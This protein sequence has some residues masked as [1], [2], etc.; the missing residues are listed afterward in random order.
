MAAPKGNDYW[1]NR[2]RTG[3]PRRFETPEELAQAFNDYFEYAENNPLKE[4]QL[5]KTKV[6]RD[7]EEVKVYKRP[8]PRILTIQ[9][10]CAF[11]GIWSSILYEYEKREGYKEI[12]AR[13]KELMYG[14]K[15][16]GAAAGLFNPSIIA[17]E[18]GLTE[19][20]ETR[21]I[22]EQPL[23]DDAESEEAD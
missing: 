18:L 17:R 10:F 9:G 14:Q 22:Q 16:E 13:A 15:I 1:R 4:A 12:I 6:Y 5:V 11:T 21:V 19:K 20:S 3:A 2:I 7:S 23:F 8:L